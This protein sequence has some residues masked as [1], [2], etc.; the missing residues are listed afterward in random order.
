MGGRSRLYID[1]KPTVLEW[2]LR[3]SG[4]KEAELSTKTDFK[5]LPK[6]L[7]G[8]T[9]PTLQQLEKLSKVTYTPLSHL[10]LSEPPD[11][12]PSPVPHFRTMD[13]D[14]P[15]KRSINLE[16]TIRFTE[17]RQEWVRDYLVEIGADPLPFVK[18]C[19]IHDDPAEVAAKIRAELGLQEAWVANQTKEEPDWPALRTKIE[20]KQIFLARAQVVEHHRS[21][22]LDPEEFRG[23]VLVD[24]YA[25]F[26]FVNS[27]DYPRAQTFTLAHELAHVW[28]GE[29]ASFDLHNFQPANNQLEHACNKI[30]AELLV[31]TQKITEQWDKFNASDDV[32][33][34]IASHFGVSRIVAA[35]RALDTGCI[36]RDTFGV[37]YEDYKRGYE[38]WMAEKKQR[39]KSGGSTPAKSTP[40]YIS[41]RFMNL[42]ITSVGEGRTLHREAYALTHLAPKTF[43]AIKKHAEEKVMSQ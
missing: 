31:P 13:N 20:N 11:D 40:A 42:L 28:I 5:R 7:D 12:P 32:Y 41:P 21:R 39:K 4:K 30:A 36:S 25:P 33:G 14:E 18:S 38:A 22:K 43:D 16:D 26:I 15:A 27:A 23:F 19:T 1:V 17:W 8:S 9:S 6:W 24:D 29:S 37:F 10:L 35:R 2:A 3:R 34:A